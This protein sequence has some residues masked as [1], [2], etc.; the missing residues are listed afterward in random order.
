MSSSEQ[1]HNPPSRTASEGEVADYTKA[2]NDLLGTDPSADWEIDGRPVW[3]GYCGD[4]TQ[5]WWCEPGTAGAAW[6]ELEILGGLED[7]SSGGQGLLLDV[8]EARE[9]AA[10]LLAIAAVAAAAEK[11]AQ[12]SGEESSW[13][14]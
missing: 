10:R 8:R 3:G 7:L 9:L 12:A 6:V 14:A 5:L 4:Q 13:G 11:P 2:V 1:I